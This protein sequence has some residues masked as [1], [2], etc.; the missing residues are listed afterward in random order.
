MELVSIVLSIQGSLMMVNNVYLNN[1]I[2]DR[3]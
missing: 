2:C 1:V 3:N